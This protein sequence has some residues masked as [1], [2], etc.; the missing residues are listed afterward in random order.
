M[1][2]NFCTKNVCYHFLSPFNK[3]GQPPIST[4]W[5]CHEVH[6]TLFYNDIKKLFARFLNYHESILDDDFKFF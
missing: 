3:N 4:V 2:I 5:K 1:A 6:P